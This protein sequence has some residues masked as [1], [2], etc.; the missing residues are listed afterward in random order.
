VLLSVARGL[1]DG[2]G[3]APPEEERRRTARLLTR[4]IH[5]V[6]APQ[7]LR[8]EG[9]G[10]G[11]R[12]RTGALSPGV[13]EQAPSVGHSEAFSCRASSL[14]PLRCPAHFFCWPP[15][16]V[17]FGADGEQHLRFLGD[18]RATFCNLPVQASRR[19]LSCSPAAA[20]WGGRPPR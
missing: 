20:G 12:T 19:P 18:C 2:L 17:S 11:S 16:Q 3:P 8:E 13:G 14:E 10:Q 15:S 7:Q 9:G 4:L 5:Q 1:H 6:G